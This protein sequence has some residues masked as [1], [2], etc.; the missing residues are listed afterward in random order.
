[1]GRLPG[2]VMA[3]RKIADEIVV[4]PIVGAAAVLAA[5]GAVFS[6]LDAGP[7]A[8][9]M[10][11]HLAV[12]NVLAPLIAAMI[13]LR[14]PLPSFSAATIWIAAIGQIA[15]LWVWH[16]PALQ[17]AAAGSFA[18]HVLLMVLLA[19]AALAFWVLLL[20]AGRKG[21]W[22][23]LGVLLVTGKLACLLGAL[24]IFAARDVYALPGLS[25]PFCTVGPSTLEDQQLAGLLMITA[26]P[27]SYL[28]AGVVIAAQMFAKLDREGANARQSHLAAR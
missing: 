18:L 15:L 21:L 3:R 13:V 20:D 8:I 7:L 17:L 2:P 22:R 1:M 27:L 9:Q 5:G 14:L 12:M 28:V 19:V 10:A 24:M 6:A 23:A 4:A 25:L 11:Q 26:C 16:A